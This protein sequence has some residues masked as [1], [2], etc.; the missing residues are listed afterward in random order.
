[1]QLRPRIDSQMAERTGLRDYASFG[2]ERLDLEYVSSLWRIRYPA[3]LEYALALPYVFQ[4]KFE[5]GRGHVTD[6]PFF[7]L[8]LSI[9]GE[10]KY[11]RWAEQP[12]AFE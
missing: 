3:W 1:M 12:E 2:E 5:L 11:C 7:L 10:E 6:H 8:F 4:T 9:R